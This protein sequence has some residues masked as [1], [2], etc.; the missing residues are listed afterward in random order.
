MLAAILASL[1][2]A[3]VPAGVDLIKNVGSTA[4]RKLLG[5]SVDD[6]LRLEN[7]VIERLKALAGLENPY[8]NPSQWV[9]DLRASFRYVAAGFLLVVGA[10]VTAYG[11]YA[12]NPNV[13]EMGGGLMAG[14][15]SFIFGERMWSAMK[16]K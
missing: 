15:W 11:S 13:M 1:V 6:Q 5:I 4:S 3:L 12:N 16:A 7:A 9:V 14:P 10:G 8:G 2:P